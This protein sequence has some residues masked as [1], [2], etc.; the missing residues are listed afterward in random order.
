MTYYIELIQKLILCS[1]EEAALIFE[2]LSGEG[3]RW[4]N[5]SRRQLA[6]AAKQAL[7]TARYMIENPDWME[8]YDQEIF[9]A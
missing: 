1:A 2:I 9:F 6:N 3:I 5:V 4:S 8:K 7:P